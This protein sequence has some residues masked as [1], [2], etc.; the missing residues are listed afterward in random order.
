MNTVSN[1]ILIIAI[2]LVL[3][4]VATFLVTLAAADWDFSKLDEGNYE[5]NTYRDLGYF[6]DLSINTVSANVNLI[7]SENGE[8]KVV[9]YEHKRIKHTVEIADGTLTV[10]ADDQRKWYDHL[11][12]FGEPK[13]DLYIPAEKYASLVIFTDTSDVTV[14]RGFTFTDVR[15]VGD[16]GDVDFFAAAENLLKIDI[17]T[18]DINIENATAGDVDLKVST[19]DVEIE[20][21]TCASLSSA[22]ST[23]DISIESLVADGRVYIKRSTGDVDVDIC[24]ASDLTVKSSSGDIELENIACKGDVSLSITTGTTEV[25]SCTCKSFSSVGDTGNLVMSNVIS[26]G[27]WNIK[28]ST[29]DVKFERCDA[30]EVYAS[31]GTG[32]VVGSFLTD[33]IIFADSG[34]GKIDVPRGTTGGKCEITTT[35][36]KIVISITK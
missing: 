36:G 26:T 22:G 24:S 34:T 25:E 16:T 20:G 13:I 14:G 23:G 18:G 1:I 2:A 8:S 21:L 35:T 31:V 15:I 27:V 9:C 6:S 4:G 30:G 12:S 3:I 32:D 10:K 7:P 28:R 11:F 29:G 17:S 33:K 5:T 19:G